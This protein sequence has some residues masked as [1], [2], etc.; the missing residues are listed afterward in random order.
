MLAVVL[1]AMFYLR[2]KYATFVNVKFVI[3]KKKFSGSSEFGFTLNS[4]VAKGE[5]LSLYFDN[6]QLICLA[7]HKP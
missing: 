5:V 2:N 7:E 3:L 4:A 6:D 1:I